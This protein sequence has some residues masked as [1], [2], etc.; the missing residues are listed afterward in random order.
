[1]K[2][3]EAKIT[4]ATQKKKQDAEVAKLKSLVTM[5]ENMKAKEAARNLRP[6]RHSSLDRG[7][8]PIAPRRCPTSWREMSPE[9][10]ERLTV[11]LA[12]RNGDKAPAGGRASQDRRPARRNLMA[13][14]NES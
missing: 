14:V 10:A 5:Y 6:A 11:E 3:V 1:V 12:N 2:D 8:Q 4:A 9:S 7:R 13:T